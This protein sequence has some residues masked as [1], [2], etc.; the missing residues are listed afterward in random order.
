[1]LYIQREERNRPKL[2]KIVN[3]FFQENTIKENTS[4]P[5]EPRESVQY[6]TYLLFSLPYFLPLLI[7]TKN[8]CSI[9]I[10]TPV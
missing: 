5:I 6:T 10:L 8:L 9:D 2:L 7:Y 1:M 4:P 3:H